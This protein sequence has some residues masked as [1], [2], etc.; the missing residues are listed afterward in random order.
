MELKITKFNMLKEREVRLVEKQI[1]RE[2]E[3][4]KMM[5]AIHFYKS[6]P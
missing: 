2:R 5:I 6:S 4:I 3:I 1:E